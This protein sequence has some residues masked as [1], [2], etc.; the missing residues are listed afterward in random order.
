MKKFGSFWG[1]GMRQPGDGNIRRRSHPGR[2]FILRCILER[3]LFRRELIQKKFP[4][5]MDL[6][7]MS[8]CSM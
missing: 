7:N 4:K 1:F 8:L 2:A 6:E 3:L 5:K